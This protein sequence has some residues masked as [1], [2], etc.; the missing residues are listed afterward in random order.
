MTQRWL[1]IQ[2]DPS[3]RRFLFEQERVDND[4]DTELDA[5]L[6][7]VETLMLGHGVFHAKIDFSSRLV[8]FWVRPDPLRYRV[9]VKEEFMHPTIFA[10]Y[11]RAP[12]PAE[13]VMPRE[14][15]HAVLS[16]FKRL[17][18]QDRTV[19]L[20]SGSVN[21][22]S[23]CVSVSFSCDGSHYLDYKEFLQRAPEFRC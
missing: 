9:H 10:L 19:Y 21:V 3:V 16:Q 7:R 2:G 12:Y 18:R 20:R 13:A 17:R 11:P 23:G 6:A 5:V 15:V 14:A 22:V 1:Q 4:F 8:T